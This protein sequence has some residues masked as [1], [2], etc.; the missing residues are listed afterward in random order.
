M[1]HKPSGRNHRMKPDEELNIVPMIDM[2]TN[3]MFF[4]MMFASVMPVMMI[5]APMPKIASTAEEVKKAKESE[6]AFEVT[7]SVSKKG[8][9]VRSD[10]G[11]KS[12]PVIAE[13]KYNYAELHTFLVQL[14]AKKPKAKELTLTPADDTPYDVM[15][16]VMDAARELVKA[17]PGFQTVPPEIAQKPESEE[18]NRLFPEITIG[19]V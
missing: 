16:E 12:I 15:I 6:N 19:G 1:A 5:N 14:H 3:L 13:G 18:F 9:D 17:D 8:F 10:A 2:V 4:L 11:S 7:V